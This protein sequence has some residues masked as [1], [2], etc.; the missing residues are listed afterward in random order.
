MNLRKT[1]VFW[2]FTLLLLLPILGVSAQISLMDYEQ[3]LYSIPVSN[4]DF[5]LFTIELGMT[6]AD[7]PAEPLLRLIDRLASHPGAVFEKDG[8]LIILAHALEDG[9]PIEGLVGKAL[10]GLARNVSLQQI[11]QGLSQLLILLAETRDLFYSKGIFNAPAGAP[12]AVPTAIPTLRF[13][14]LLIHVSGTIGDF[15]E[16][17]GSPFEGHLLY[18]GMHNR[19]TML[20]GITLLPEDVELVLDRIEPSD[21]TQVALVAVR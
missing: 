12:Q 21:L 2:T 9:L 17:G 5:I 20:Q 19:L 18:Q 13:N 10:E 14:Q 15:L 7:F 6:Q 11:E 4:P 16:S 8:I 3:G 1:R